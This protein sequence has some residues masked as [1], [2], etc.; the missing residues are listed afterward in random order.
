M[1]T[2]TAIK[3]YGDR[4]L[5]LVAAEDDKKSTDAV[6]KLK[7]ASTNDKYEAKIYEKGGHGTG[8]FAGDVGLQD[9]LEQF[10]TKSL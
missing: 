6:R 5:L 1:P 10:L 8:I 4:P 9:L 2:E 7:S 3:S